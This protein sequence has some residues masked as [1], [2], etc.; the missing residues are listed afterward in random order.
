MSG[1]EKD[2]LR[3]LGTELRDYT[4]QYTRQEL[5]QIEPSPMSVNE[6]TFI[7][8]ELCPSGPV[9]TPLE[10]FKLRK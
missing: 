5:Q 7:Q 10:Y 2:A 3:M 9:Y 8:S 4:A 6:F 1:E